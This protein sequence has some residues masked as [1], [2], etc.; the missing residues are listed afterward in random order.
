MP[1][2]LGSRNR[3]RHEYRNPIERD[4]DEERMRQLLDRVAPLIMRRNKDQVADDLP[5]KTE[6][7]Q[8]LDLDQAQSE[9]YRRIK[10][11]EWD[12]LQQQLT[13]AENQGRQ[14]IL[15]L[16]ALLK[17]RQVCCDPKLIGADDAPSAKRGHC[18][19]MLRELVDEDRAVLVF[20]Q[21]TS[22]LDLLAEDLEA[23]GM[24]YLM[25]TGRTQNRK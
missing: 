11:A 7:E 6:I 8:I 24:K 3:F 25:L 20:S 9:L 16:S 4:G 19:D 23:G 15:I 10:D 1:G 22:M 17:L 12:G 18:I 21:F 14:Q 5:P 13:Q 2:C